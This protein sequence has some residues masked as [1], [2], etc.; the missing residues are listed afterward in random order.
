MAIAKGGQDAAQIRQGTEAEL[1]KFMEQP[2]QERGPL[3]ERE[4]EQLDTRINLARFRI[5]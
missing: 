2:P 5:S 4:I 1:K 3:S